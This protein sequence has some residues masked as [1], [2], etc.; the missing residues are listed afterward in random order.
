VTRLRQLSVL[1]NGYRPPSRDRDVMTFQYLD[2]VDGVHDAVLHDTGHGS[3]Q[4]VSPGGGS[5]RQSFVVYF[6]LRRGRVLRGSQSMQRRGKVLLPGHPRRQRPDEPPRGVQEPAAHPPK[7]CP[8][9][10]PGNPAVYARCVHGGSPGRD[11]VRSRGRGWGG[12]GLK[13]NGRLLR[14]DLPGSLGGSLLLR[15][16]SWS[17]SVNRESR[18]VCQEVTPGAR[19]DSTARL[20]ITASPSDWLNPACNKAGK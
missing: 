17:G 4:H 14:P 20:S 19:A 11:T 7:L 1:L 6:G 10:S 12:G 16:G 18:W 8:G 3:R 13:K 9:G 15:S 2:A 5:L